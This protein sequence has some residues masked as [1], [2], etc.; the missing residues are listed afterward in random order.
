[1]LLD[2]LLGLGDNVLEQGKEDQVSQILIVPRLGTISP[3]SSK[4]TDIMHHCGMHSVDRIERGIVYSVLVENDKNLTQTELKLLQPLLHD[5]MTE[6]MLGPDVL[7]QA[8]FDGVAKIF[9]A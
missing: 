6:S 9:F 1:M 3:W 7:L 4:A 2:S 5:R 8:G